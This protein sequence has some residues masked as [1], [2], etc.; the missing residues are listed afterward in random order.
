MREIRFAYAGGTIIDN[1]VLSFDY[2][3]Q[4][5][6]RDEDGVAIPANAL[7]LNGGTIKHAGD[8]ATV[9]DLAH[10]AAPAEPTRKVDGSRSSP[11]TD[12]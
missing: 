8:G 7:A 10:D 4:A 2:F 5:T 6:D 9:A 1:D 12:G 3:V 11:P